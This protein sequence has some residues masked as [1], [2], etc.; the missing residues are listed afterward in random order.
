LEFGSFGINPSI[1][2][3]ATGHSI[4]L[5]YHCLHHDRKRAGFF[6]HSLHDTSKVLCP[7]QINQFLSPI[8]LVYVPF[9][10]SNLLGTVYPKN[11]ITKAGKP[12]LAGNPRGEVQR[13]DF[14]SRSPDFNPRHPYNRPKYTRL[15]LLHRN[16][17]L[18]PPRPSLLL[19]IYRNP[20]IRLDELPICTLYSLLL[21]PLSLLIFIR[22]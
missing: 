9:S 7:D 19:T 6:S 20:G 15:F 14:G 22:A 2:S 16:R 12:I 17:P 4:P 5:H 21:L 11:F 10:P 18:N 13:S 1:H 3:C 8:Y